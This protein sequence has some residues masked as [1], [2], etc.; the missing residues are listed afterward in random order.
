MEQQV[1]SAA[2]VVDGVVESA[3][4]REQ[5]DF[6][7]KKFESERTVVLRVYNYFRIVIS[8][9]LLIV[10]YE[11][12][13]QSFVGAVAPNIFQTV[14]IVYLML[15]V[16]AGFAVLVSK[17]KR[18]SN[19]TAIATIVVFDIF[20]LSLLLCVSGGVESGLGYLILFTVSFGS[21][22]LGGQMSF[23]F[24]AIATVNCITSEI[25]LHNAGEYSESQHF[26]EVAILG[27]AFFVVN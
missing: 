4:L 5:K 27:T 3:I 12:S 11:V 19:A 2:E 10:F 14:A 6:R 24:P 8:F 7:L 20:F 23:L 21:V 13:G 17:D 22:M 26:F 9:F 15:N 18:L 16:G 25:Y 1:S